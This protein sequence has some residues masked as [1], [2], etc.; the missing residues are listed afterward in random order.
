VNV[1][2]KSYYATGRA[3]WGGTGEARSCLRTAAGDGR[4]ERAPGDDREGGGL[5]EVG[6]RRLTDTRRVAGRGHPM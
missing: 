6:G 1:I 3:G 2:R 4:R 5:P